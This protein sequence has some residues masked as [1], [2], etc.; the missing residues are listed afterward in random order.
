MARRFSGRVFACAVAAL[1][2]ASFAAGMTTPLFAATQA[3]GTTSTQ[4]AAKPQTTEKKAATKKKTAKKK[5]KPAETASS[6]SRKLATV[7]STHLAKADIAALTD[8]FAEADRKNWPEAMRHA[9]RLD[10]PVAATL[11]QWSR[12]VAQD[13]GATLA[14][15]VAFQERYA[16]WPRQALLS[17]RAEEALLAY[18]MS[19][20]DMLNW[21]ATHPPVTG[22]GKIRFGQSLLAAG[23][24][25]EGKGWIQRGWVEDDF[26]S[27]RQKEI[28]ANFRSHLTGSTHRARL[29][30]LLWDGRTRDAK[31]TAALI[32][33]DANALADARIKLMN[34]SNEATGA[35]SRVPA[36]LKN[37]PGLIFDRVR[38]ERRRGNDEAALPLILTAPNKPHVAVAA[39]AWWIERR[40][41]A[42]KALT[43]GQYK[44]AYQIV[45][46]HGL[47]DGTDFADAEFM[48]GW[49]SLQYLNDASAALV[50]FAKLA[51]GVST[52]ISKA[53]AE[54]W[55][56]R[57]ASARGDKRTAALYYKQA[58]AYPTTFYGQLGMAALAGMNGSAAR[59]HLAKDPRLS[60]DDKAAFEKLELVHATHI[61]HDFGRDDQMWSFALHLGDILEEPAHVAALSD[62]ALAFG[63]P[64]LSLR[65]AKKAAQRNIVLAQ[66][67]YP[68]SLMPRFSEKG[69]RVEKALVYG[70]SR[71]ESEFDGAVVS[72]AGARGLMQLM[73]ATAKRVARQISVPYSSSRLTS[74]PAYNA[75]LGAAHLGDLV[76]NYSGS[77]I[78]SVAAY[79]AGATRVGEWN[80][81]FGDPR[82]TAVDPIDWIENIPF[83]ETR[84]YVQRVMENLEVYRSRLSGNVE[85]V[86]IV[87]DLRRNT[88]APIATPVPTPGRI[89][90]ASPLIPASAMSPVVE[91]EEREPAV[92]AAAKP[93]TRLAEA[94]PAAIGAVP[95]PLAPKRRAHSKQ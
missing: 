67:A 55:R 8:A 91:E 38:Y 43:D 20:E 28:L 45:S 36:R 25:E 52:P 70:L 33:A 61:L 11:V 94:E 21:F 3:S 31:L 9:R 71:Q 49:I 51:D 4:T 5:K 23:R 62:L 80:D 82:S 81:K 90:L 7:R 2:G 64:K 93:E 16:D 17:R 6:R 46:A 65:V 79:N 74:D 37:D 86:R 83:S 48:S 88:G 13:S 47:K 57:A 85:R 60:K 14:E 73:P 40:I 19:G 56:G 72:S 10:D 12:L 24:K 53:R 34:G 58:A 84:N 39:D 18:P 32:G 78:M 68:T 75:M 22:E 26:S 77:Y 76:E 63:D 69:P 95:T 29:D 92:E 35:L 50:H 87:D 42:R 30:R 59:L 89:P 44:E 27:A 41:A 1:L 15:I 54:Y 66:R